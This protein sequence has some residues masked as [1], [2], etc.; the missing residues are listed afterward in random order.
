MILRC[1]TISFTSKFKLYKSLVT[2]TLLYGCETRTLLADTEK[3]TGVFE[4][5][6]LRKH[7]RISYL[8]HKTNDWVR[9]KIKCLVGPQEPILATLKRR[10]LQ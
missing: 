4:T 1:D 3:R 2:S 5:E 6:C 9:S 8:E 10:K 7:L